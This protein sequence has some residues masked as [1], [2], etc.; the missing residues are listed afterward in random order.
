[1]QQTHNIRSKQLT[2]WAIMI[3]PLVLS[4]CYNLSEM[5]GVREQLLSTPDTLSAY[6]IVVNIVTVICTLSAFWL[7]AGI[8]S[9]V[10]TVRFMRFFAIAVCVLDAIRAIFH[11]CIKADNN[12]IE[13]YSLI[14]S[15]FFILGVVVNMYFLGGMER[16]NPDQPVLKQVLRMWLVV[17][18][19]EA[20]IVP[21]Y[22]SVGIQNAANIVSS[23]LFIFIY[24][25]LF[26]TSV[27]SGIMDATPVPKGAYKFWNSYFK[28]FLIAYLGL[29]ILSSVLA[30]FISK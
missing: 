1:M 25:K 22:V 2:A 12:N 23:L 7:M 30:V 9:N 20:G 5:F 26:T 21:L 4:V 6:S 19:L 10:A 8:A 17:M 24:Y 29:V 11:Y 18:A 13:Y 28:F 27:F 14:L 15:A 16:N 3:V